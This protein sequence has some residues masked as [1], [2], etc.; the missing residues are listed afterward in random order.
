MVK[1]FICL[2]LLFAVLWGCS[3]SV[4]SNAYPH[5]KN[6]AVRPFENRSSQFD[7][8]DTVTDGLTQKFSRDGRLK[9]VTQQ[10]DSTLEGEIL[11]F[12]ESV[13]SYDSANNVQD[14]M[15]RLSCS[16]VFTDLINNE[17]IYENKN[18][19]L[20]EPYAAPGQSSSTAKSKTKEE[21]TDELITR[22]FNTII[23]NS[24]ETW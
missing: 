9:L 11:D 22:L 5:L 18:L 24:L 10:P 16:V 4:F 13:Y 23:Q 17:V 1:K 21:A 12:S 7:L 8:G 3:Y 15:L 2:G 19:A 20:T 6:I 14:Y